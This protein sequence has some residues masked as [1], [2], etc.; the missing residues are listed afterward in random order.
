VHDFQ[1]FCQ[2]EL[3]GFGTFR[4]AIWE[5][6]YSKLDTEPVGDLASYP[7]PHE[8]AADTNAVIAA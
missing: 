4:F 5:I 3:T 8:N 6:L 2:M 7:M 1:S